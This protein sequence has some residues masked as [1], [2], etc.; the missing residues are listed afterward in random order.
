M[1]LLFFFY[2][3]LIATDK[4]IASAGEAS[5]SDNYHNQGLAYLAIDGNTDGH[6]G[7]GSV[8]HTVKEGNEA[9]WRLDFSNTYYVS[10]ILIWNRVD[11]CSERLNGV[12]VRIDDHE[13]IIA[14]LD[15]TKGNPIG[16]EVDDDV[17]KITIYGGNSVLS[18]AEVEVFGEIIK[19][20]AIFGMASQSDNLLS[21]YGIAGLAIDGNTDGDWGAGSVTHTNSVGKDAWWRLEFSNYNT[22]Y[23]SK[24]KIWNRVDCCS[25]RLNGVTVR[26]DDQENIL[27]ELDT[28]KGNPI[29]IKVG[30]YVNFITIYGGNSA[31]SLAE[32]E[33]FG[34]ISIKNIAREGS[35]SQS[36]NADP[37][38]GHA[39][40]AIDGNTD[41][42]WGGKSVTHT[43]TA[44]KDAWWRLDFPNTYYVYTIR[45]WNRLDCCS[46]RLNGATVRVD[47][48]ENILAELVTSKGNPIVIKVD[49]DV[50]FITIYGGNS[51]LSL[52]E[53]EVFG[54]IK[55]YGI[56]NIASEGKATQSDNLDPEHGHAGVAIDGNTN[57]TWGGGSVT[58]TTTAGKDAW[59]RLDF[60]NTY[61]VYTIRIWNR[62]ACCS[63][64]LNGATVSVDNRE[65]IL[66]ELLTSKGNPIVIKVDDDV[67]FITIYGGNSVL[68]LAEVEVFGYLKIY[69]ILQN[70]ASE[71]KASQSDNYDPVH[72]H[73]EV[74]IDGNTDGN[75]GGQ[76]VTHT[77][78]AGKDA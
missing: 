41:G 29:E 16:I 63:G 75:W 34:P 37:E 36:D 51:V 72:G 48:R 19:N 33:V 55:I 73:A 76:S 47:N 43:S 15:T 10:K 8:T 35:A 40:V 21:V 14:K 13:N 12:T 62:E 27:A 22:H 49:D 32:V 28:R 54:Y 71:G 3:G 77:T 59:W 23:V 60:P 45:I 42:N 50:N 9:W 1:F 44:G 7:G 26:V 64:R 56:H 65:N 31:L 74:A 52:A 70:I 20:I 69:G 38:Q 30:E 39:G 17:N 6:W 58:H 2:F 78:T 25:E 67:N 66:A 24:M 57:G 5:Q 11:C 46:E 61:Y 18:L 53:V 68:S 4:N